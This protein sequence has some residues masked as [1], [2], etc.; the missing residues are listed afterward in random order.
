MG[1]NSAFKG[2]NRAATGVSACSVEAV[3]SAPAVYVSVS[4]KNYLTHDFC[5]VCVPCAFCE[6]GRKL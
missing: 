4:L 6:V 1:F 5:N 3:L 2:L